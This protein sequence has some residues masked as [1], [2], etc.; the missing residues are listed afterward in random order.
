[1]VNTVIFMNMPAGKP[2]IKTKIRHANRITNTNMTDKNINPKKPYIQT[3]KGVMLMTK[4][5][6]AG[7]FDP[8]TIGHLDILKEAA[9]IFDEV[10]VVIAINANKT[11]KYNTLYMKDAIQ[12]VIEN[13]N[14]KNC[15]AVVYNGLI[16]QYCIDNNIGYTVRGLR[17]FIDFGYEQN[18]AGVN[19]QIFPSLVTVYLTAEHAD[20][21]SSMV[22]E[23]NDYGQDVSNFVPEEILPVLRTFN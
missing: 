3:K 2:I 7:S 16:A 11:K 21:S 22:R 6:Y 1:M 13:N 8:F 5:I 17:N 4:A 12:K 23:L 18:I 14:L 15:K 10:H 19:K 20:I 9:K